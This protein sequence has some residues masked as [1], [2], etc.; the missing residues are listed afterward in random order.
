MREV[1]LNLRHLRPVPLA[2]L[3]GYLAHK[4]H[5]LLRPYSRTLRR[6]LWWSS[7]W[8][9]VLM[10]EVSPPRILPLEPYRS[11]HSNKRIFSLS[12]RPLAP[13]FSHLMERALSLSPAL[14]GYLA[15]K[16]PPPLRTLQ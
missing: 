12:P 5:P 13:S 8:G 9:L 1:L 4:K 2:L 3:Q 6:V 7:R 16:K 15:R 10:S 14:Q 11:T